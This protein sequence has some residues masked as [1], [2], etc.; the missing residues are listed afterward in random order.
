M[1]LMYSLP[2]SGTYRKTSISER[3]CSPIKRKRE[4]TL[5]NES[6][7]SLGLSLLSSPDSSYE[8]YSVNPVTGS[9][10][11]CRRSPRLLNNGYYVLTEDSYTWDDEGNVSLTPSKIKLSYKENLVRI[12][13]RRRKARR[14]L[15]SLFSDMTE[16]CQ[17]WLDEK[18][19]GGVRHPPLAE[20]SWMEHSTTDLDTSCSFTYDDSETMPT[21]LAHEPMVQEEIITETCVHQEHF[22]QSLGGLL[23]V[24]PPSA[25]LS[26]SCCPPKPQPADFPMAKALFIILMVFIFSAIFSRCLLW[27]LT[28]AFSTFISIM[29]YLFVSQSGPM[30]KWRKAKTEDITSKNE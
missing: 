20:S 26:N 12:F 21:K 22:G 15:A 27:G 25:F 5:A 16:T 8:C 18:V 19:F 28:M 23:D 9:P 7:Q 30:G 6:C 13:R 24:P 10:S 17:S 11:S 1:Q 29:I 3:V 14:S 4:K 2:L